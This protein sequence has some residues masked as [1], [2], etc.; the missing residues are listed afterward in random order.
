[1]SMP[2]FS[3]E[4]VFATPAP[5]KNHDRFRY[6]SNLDFNPKYFNTSQLSN[7]FQQSSIHIENG[8]RAGSVCSTEEE[9]EDVFSQDSPVPDSDYSSIPEVPRR[10]VS[11]QTFDIEDDFTQPFITETETDD[12]EGVNPPEIMYHAGKIQMLYL[13]IV[14]SFFVYRY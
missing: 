7:T 4:Y 10:Y 12:H 2:E 13:S 6:R 1:V 3:E 14:L 9:Y 8:N 11:N 5:K